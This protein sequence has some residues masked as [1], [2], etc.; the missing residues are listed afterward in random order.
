MG[1][2]TRKQKTK[3]SKDFNFFQSNT[4]TFSEIIYSFRGELMPQRSIVTF[5]C[6]ENQTFPDGMSFRNE[7][8]SKES[9]KNRDAQECVGMVLLIMGIHNKVNTCCG[10][11]T[12]NT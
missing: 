6:E 9:E 7:E 2:F 11:E 4:A 5:E 8:C 3:L 10:I 1:N 12:E